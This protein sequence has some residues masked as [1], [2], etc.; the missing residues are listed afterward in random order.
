MWTG[1]RQEDEMFSYIT[2]LQYYRSKNVADE[3]LDR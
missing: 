2:C 3:A 1:R